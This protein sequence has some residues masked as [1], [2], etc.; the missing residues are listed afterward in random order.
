MSEKYL[1]LHVLSADT[2]RRD[3]KL[4]LKRTYKAQQHLT[5]KYNLLQ[6]ITI[7]DKPDTRSTHPP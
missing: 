2:V 4:Y 6:I 7:A 1:K 5:F 3:N